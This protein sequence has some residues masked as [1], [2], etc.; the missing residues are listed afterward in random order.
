MKNIIKGDVPYIKE[1]HDYWNLPKTNSYPEPI[2]D[3]IQYSF[4][5]E[6]RHLTKENLQDKERFVQTI[7][8]HSK[9]SELEENLE[10]ETAEL[11]NCAQ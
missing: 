2:K 7:L 1:F 6:K 8:T 11:L 10:L 9:K 3:K 4:G 5:V